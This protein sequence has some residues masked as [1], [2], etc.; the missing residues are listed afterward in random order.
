M[1]K[2]PDLLRQERATEYHKDDLWVLSNSADFG[3]DCSK[4]VV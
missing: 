3:L 1:H 2:M 4:V